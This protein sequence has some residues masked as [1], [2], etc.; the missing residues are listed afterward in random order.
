MDNFELLERLGAVEPPDLVVT[1]QVAAA[2]E[3]S[4]SVEGA[5]DGIRSRSLRLR[6]RPLLISALAVVVIVATAVTLLSTGGG[7]TSPITSSWQ[8]E[9]FDVEWFRRFNI[10]FS[11]WYVGSCGRRTVRNVATERVGS[12]SGLL[13]V[14]RLFD[15]LRHEWKLCQY[16]S[17]CRDVRVTLREH[18]LRFDLDG[19]SNAEWFSVDE[20]AGLQ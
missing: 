10:T 3:G 17:K 8:S 14:S 4:A 16:R 19:L 15:V 2:L 18:R 1:A 20:P 9:P 13:H 6:R 11:P 7:L 12:A 5:K